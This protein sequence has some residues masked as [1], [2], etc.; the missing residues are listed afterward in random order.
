ME[1]LSDRHHEVPRWLLDHF[2]KGNRGRLWVGFKEDRRVA[3]VSTSNAFVR[4]GANSRFDYVQ[5]PDATFARVKSD[6]AERVLAEFDSLACIAA[7]EL[8]GTARRW[9]DSALVP[10]W[11]APQ[12]VSIC[13]RLILVQAR[14]TREAQDRIGVGDHD[15]EL[16]ASHFRDRADELGVTLPCTEELMEDPEIVRVFDDISQ[17]NRATFAGGQHPLDLKQDAD[18]LAQR[19]L[20][21]AVIKPSN[22]SFVIGSHGLTAGRTINGWDSWLPIAPD[23]A[24]SHS[25][26]PGDVQ[27]R[28]TPQAFI[29]WHN[30]TALSTSER[31][32]GCREDTLRDLLATQD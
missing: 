2:A 10:P 32:G 3:L 31:V 7:R 16:I 14:R 30:R 26:K 23:V 9:R 13:K 18:L 25:D 12:V 21:I 27:I 20:R 24:I 22:G 28:A 4:R 15:S 11:L 8:I 29:E 19:G 5:Q 6:E 1:T 17:N